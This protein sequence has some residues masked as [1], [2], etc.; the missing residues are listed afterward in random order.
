MTS[1]EELKK[2]TK[3]S[4]EELLSLLLETAEETILEMTNRTKFPKRLDKTKVKLAVIAYNRSGT[5][6]ETSRS[7]GGITSAFTDLPADILSVIN[8]NRLAKVG[9]KVYEKTDTETT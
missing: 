6:G 1:L 3:E 5:E 2:L 7:E 8:K 9:G 4:D